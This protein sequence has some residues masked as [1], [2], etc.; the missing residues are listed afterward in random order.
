MHEMKRYWLWIAISLGIGIT[1]PLERLHAASS[2][3]GFDLSNLSIE[4]KEI[5]SG[6]PPR[7]GIPALFYPKFV[8]AREVDYLK[9]DERI[10]GISIA[11][12]AKAYPIKILDRHEIVNDRFADRFAV[13]TYCPLCG[14]GMSFDASIDGRRTFGVSGL[15]YNSDV[16]LYDRQSDSLWSQILGKAVSGPMLDRRLVG[17]PTLNTTWGQWK[18]D[19]PNTLVLS[20]DTGYATDYNRS[21]YGNYYRQQ[22]IMFPVNEKS[23]IYHSKARVLGLTINGQSKAYPLIELAN[24]ASSV[25]DRLA[26]LSITIEYDSRSETAQAF[27]DTGIPIIATEMYWFAWYAFHP[28]SAVYQSE[29]TPPS[30][31]KR[32]QLNSTVSKTKKN[33]EGRK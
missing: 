3:N 19:H 21:V 18:V 27:D 14:S 29:K 4:R 10:L 6:G 8:S 5:R 12:V 15:L 31:R 9:D 13:V 11:G 30:Q 16:L 23:R 26:G 20:M 24:E 28:N 1:A 22:G 2:L 33:A 17:V 7:D 32:W 25:T